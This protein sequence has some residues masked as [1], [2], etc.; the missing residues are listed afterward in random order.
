MSSGNTLVASS[1]GCGPAF[2]LGGCMGLAK[3]RASLV[4]LHTRDVQVQAGEGVKL[5]ESKCEC[6][7]WREP[8]HVKVE[9]EFMV[10]SAPN[11]GGRQALYREESA[12][13]ADEGVVHAR[14][15]IAGCKNRVS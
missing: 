12:V 4:N 6:R 3:L 11:Y 14:K 10:R 9:G 8:L 1:P 13:Y 2:E 5:R 7:Y 15:P